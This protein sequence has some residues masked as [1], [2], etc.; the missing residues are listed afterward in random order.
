MLY[1]SISQA[2]F[3]DSD[4][5]C[6]SFGC[7]IISDGFGSDVYDV[8]NNAT[9]GTVPVGSPL[10]RWPNTIQGT[11][12]INIIETGTTH[13]IPTSLPSTS[14]GTQLAIDSNGN[15]TG[16]ILMSDN[17]SNGYLDASESLSSLTLTHTTD[18]VFQGN[19]VSHSFYLTSRNTRV[20]M[21]ARATVATSSSAFGSATSLSDIPFGVS[22]TRS[23]ND[24]GLSYGSRA[25]NGDFS[26]VA[27]INNLG[28]IATTYTPIATFM[29]ADGIRRLADN[30]NTAYRQS[31]R[32][33]LLY[34]YPTL[35]LSQ[36]EGAI[37][38]RV[39]YAPYKR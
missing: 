23:G 39:E 11:G 2:S 18:V 33:N 34:G 15:G 17:N 30:Q 36:G 38:F 8:Y 37:Q 7:V 16:D 27:G 21:R 20:E 24:G 3:I 14:N 5:W 25:R 12:P 1:G 35:D 29:H 19:T 32:F 10:I 26:T 31:L 13:A 28:D 4:F 6:Q 22:I 9:G